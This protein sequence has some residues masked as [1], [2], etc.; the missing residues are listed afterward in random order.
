MGSPYIGEIR[1]FAGN[2]APLGWEVCRGQSLSISEYDA[3]FTLIG[4]TYGGDGEMTFNLPDLRSRVPVHMGTQGAN[5]YTIG[6]AGGTERVAL[7]TQQLPG[8][9]HAPLANATGNSLTPGGNVWA[10]SPAVQFVE[11][12][13]AN[14]DA[15][16]PADS[17][18]SAGGGQPHENRI[19]FLAVNFIISLYGLD[20]TQS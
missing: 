7:T 15:S 17:I 12:L 9:T 10:A 18:S 5:T 6:Q 11:P 14:L 4:T 2:F 19:P 1:M 16:M 20:P 3:L 8:H 13:P